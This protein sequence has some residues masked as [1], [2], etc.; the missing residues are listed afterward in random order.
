MRGALFAAVQSD[1]GVCAEATIRRWTTIDDLAARP[2]RCWSARTSS[3]CS[4]TRSTRSRRTGRGR[5]VLVAGE[6]GIGKTALLHAFC[7]ELTRTARALGR[8]RGAVHAASAR[9][10][11][12][13]RRRDRR[14][15]RGARRERRRS[16][17]RVGRAPARAAPRGR[18]PWSCSR[19]CTGRTRRRSTS[20]PAARP[21]D[22]D[23]ARARRRHAT[24]TTS[25][26]A[27]I[28][29]GSC[30]ASCRRAGGLT[31][32]TLAPLSPAAVAELAEPYGV[33]ADELYRRTAGNPFFVTEA[34]AAGGASVPDSVRD[35]VL[36]RAA[37][38]APRR[39]SSCSTRWRSC[40]RA[41][42]S[43]CSRRWP[44]TGSTT[45]RSASRRG[46]CTPSAT[47]SRS[48]TRSR[49]SPSRS[50]CRRNRRLALHRR[51]LAALADPPGRRHRS[52]AALPS[53]R[54]GRRRR[55]RARFAP[56]AAERAAALGAHRE[57]AA[58]YAR[59][60][61]FADGLATAERAALLERR[62]CECYLTDQKDE[63]IEALEH[64][65]ERHRALGERRGRATRSAG[66]RSPLVSRRSAE[67]EA[68]P[69]R[70]RAARGAAARPR[71]GDG[72]TRTWRRSG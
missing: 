33:D 19:T 20:D 16:R 59:A 21:Q 8:L 28:R 7:A 2:R 24:A 64:A 25:S 51:A 30:S 67:A 46:C 26:T 48:G 66:S 1:S 61:R 44:A 38:L 22:R 39:A 18:R 4:P 36:A 68:G 42:S 52:R 13:H 9:A 49:A 55:R 45:S 31:R 11:A 34:L 56:A 60:L 58:Q 29:S 70:R 15:A 14:R 63:A 57:A 5:L 65:L 71:A 32:L 23:G 3:A 62:S 12:R 10:A 35:A 6:A 50:R 40:R 17:R 69:R 27:T 37:R 41:P 54:G 53:R 47:R 72:R 43:G